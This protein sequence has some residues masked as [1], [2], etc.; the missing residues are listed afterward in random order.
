[1]MGNWFKSLNE[2]RKS[3]ADKVSNW[4]AI[5]KYAP[6][7]IFSGLFLISYAV[8]LDIFYHLIFLIGCIIGFLIFASYYSAIV[9]KN[10]SNFIFD[11]LI[12]VLAVITPYQRLTIMLSNGFSGII[13]IVGF[14]AIITKINKNN[15]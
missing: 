1:M 10:G 14:I 11:I 8:W 3:N 4:V 13:L 9:Y 12:V 2:C 7:L 15:L 5:E 6:L